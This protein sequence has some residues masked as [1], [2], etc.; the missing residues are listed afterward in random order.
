MLD[1]YLKINVEQHFNNAAKTS[2]GLMKMMDALP[3]RNYGEAVVGILVMVMK[4]DTVIDDVTRVSLIAMGL[5]VV[6][7]HLIQS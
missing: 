7:A 4:M 6:E 3:I 1:V 5:I 2:D